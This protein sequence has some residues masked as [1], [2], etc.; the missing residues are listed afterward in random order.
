M[1]GTTPSGTTHRLRKVRPGEPHLYV[2]GVQIASRDLLAD[3]SP[4]DCL[5]CLARMSDEGPYGHAAAPVDAHRALNE[6]V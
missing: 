5:Q 3:P 1:N 6:G 4:V 2:C